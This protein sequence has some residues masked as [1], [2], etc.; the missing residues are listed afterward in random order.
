MI[1]RGSGSGTDEAGDGEGEGEGGN[2]KGDTLS[3]EFAVREWL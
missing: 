1:L 3:L 2:P